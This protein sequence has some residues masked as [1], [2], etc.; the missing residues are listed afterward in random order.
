MAEHIA[1]DYQRQ[2]WL[3]GEEARQ[4]LIRQYRFELDAHIDPDTGPRLRR[5]SGIPEIDRRAIC[6]RLARE[7]A[8]LGA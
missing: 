4:E 5:L 8:E 3:R 1:Y 7:L 2:R 6:L